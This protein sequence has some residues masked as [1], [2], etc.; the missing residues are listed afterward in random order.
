M[1]KVNLTLALLTKISVWDKS[2]DLPVDQEFIKMFD[3]QNRQRQCYPVI[4]M[5]FKC[6]SRMTINDIKYHQ[7]AWSAIGVDGVY[8]YPDKFKREI[9]AISWFLIKIHRD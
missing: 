9:T 6:S 2:K 7:V 5:Y 4:S 8:M 1:K 3:V